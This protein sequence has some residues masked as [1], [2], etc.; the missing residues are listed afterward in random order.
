MDSDDD[1]AQPLQPAPAAP[2]RALAAPSTRGGSACGR[3]RV[4]VVDSDTDNDADSESAAPA[5][6]AGPA[7]DAAAF[8][9]STSTS[10]SSVCAGT[11]AMGSEPPACGAIDASSEDEADEPLSSRSQW[12]AAHRVADHARVG[13]G[14]KATSR[15]DRPAGGKAVG[16]KAAAG[17]SAGAEATGGSGKATKRRASE[18][19]GAAAS[20][21]GDACEQ[22]AA[23]VRSQTSR[24]AGSGGGA[25]AAARGADSGGGAGMATHGAGGGGGVAAATH[26]AGSGGEVA[27]AA[28][29]GSA[30][31]GDAPA[32]ES[33]A[34]RCAR[35]QAENAAMRAQLGLDDAAHAIR[36]QTA[37]RAARASHSHGATVR[38]AGG[39]RTLPPGLRSATALTMA[40]S[41][42]AGLTFA[43]MAARA[44][45]GELDER[46][47]ELIDRVAGEGTGSIGE[48]AFRL[49]DEAPSQ[50]EGE[51]SVVVAFWQEQPLGCAFFRHPRPPLSQEAA[52]GPIEGQCDLALLLVDCT[53]GGS[54]QLARALSA[55]VA[56]MAARHGVSVLRLQAFEPPALVDTL[57]ADG[58][59]VGFLVPAEDAGLEPQL[60]IELMQ[61]AT[62][63]ATR[64]QV[65]FLQKHVEAAEDAL[66]AEHGAPAGAA[67][68]SGSADGHFDVRTNRAGMVG[69]PEASG[70]LGAY[71]D[72]LPHVGE[73]IVVWEDKATLESVGASQHFLAC[74]AAPPTLCQHD[75]VT[76]SAKTREAPRPRHLESLPAVTLT[77]RWVGG[78]DASRTRLYTATEL[79]ELTPREAADKELSLRCGY[80]VAE[81]GSTFVATHSWC[82]LAVRVGG[83]GWAEHLAEDARPPPELLFSW[84]CD[85]WA[86][87]AELVM[88]RALNSIHRSRPSGRFA[89]GPDGAGGGCQAR[90]PAARAQASAPAAAGGADDD[91]AWSGSRVP[92]QALPLPPEDMFM[93]LE[94]YCGQAPLAVAARNTGKFLVRG[95]DRDPENV[96]QATDH[97]GRR[98]SDGSKVRGVPICD[99]SCAGRCDELHSTEVR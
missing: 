51:Y 23:P 90:K 84:T 4:T 12:L 48:R 62:E 55:Y 24:R 21:A 28:R 47:R 7:S 91:D 34:E 2:A 44:L 3:S 46:L 26:G 82:R 25:A 85:E 72:G 36:R 5:G 67:E 68:D 93:L 79:T 65:A 18:G 40:P 70:V 86:P 97:H 94:S 50:A 77:L 87:T 75:G 20:S 32:G 22:A 35:K 88:R 95:L 17:V 74:L 43:R 56:M 29:S 14:R 42:P 53:V 98:L 10:V 30:S 78:T 45:L 66:R 61:G 92:S 13:A 6:H 63:E 57:M 31:Q 1:E 76:T 89:M 8:H 69:A 96:W 60:I 59:E 41:D 9:A 39:S 27:A 99:G 49:L 52:A 19:R 73:L 15:G 33:F 80:G 37:P 71:Q 58:A 11:S 81:D 64:S 83:P 16:G 54:G 38:G